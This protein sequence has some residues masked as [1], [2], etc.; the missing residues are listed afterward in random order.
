MT[1]IIVESLLAIIVGIAFYSLLL[2]DKQKNINKFILYGFALIFFGTLI[3]ITDNFPLLN[4]YIVIG[5]NVYQSLLEKVVG[6]LFG[7]ALLAIGFWKWQPGI[8]ERKTGNNKSEIP[9]HEIMS[10]EN[11]LVNSL[12]FQQELLNAIPVPVFYKNKEGIYLGCNREFEAFLGISEGEI[13]GKSV[14]DVAP[15]E[16]ADGYYEKDM[17]LFNNP[18]TQIYEFEV[19]N[20]SDRIRNVIFHKATF[21]DSN[22]EV[23]GLNGAVLDITARKEA[24]DEREKLISELKVALDKVK[25]LSGFL[26]ICASCKKIRDDKGYWNQIEEYIREHSEAEF[27]HSICPECVEKLYPE[28]KD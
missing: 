7:F 14:Y 3:D 13:I 19:K 10:T 16:L 20:K 4:K 15:K 18:G 23:S 12:T 24:E 17:E 9:D 25:V 2:K 5:D 11:R 6:F 26:P 28:L 22:G 21:Y 1:D 27:S 8:S